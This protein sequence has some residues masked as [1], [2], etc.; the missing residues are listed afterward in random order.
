MSVIIKTW[1]CNICGYVNTDQ[2]CKK[3]GGSKKEQ[4]YTEHNLTPIGLIIGVNLLILFALFITVPLIFS[5]GKQLAGWLASIIL[6]LEDFAYMVFVIRINKSV[7]KYIAAKERWEKHK[8][9]QEELESGIKKVE[10][11]CDCGKCYPDGAIFCAIDGNPLK[12][13]VID[14]YILTC[15]TCK[16]IFQEGTKFCPACGREIMK[17]SKE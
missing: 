10:M 11:V 16:K 12:R 13:R 6:L 8:I 2:V 15:P 14:N 7:K 17:M 3:C 4:R 5:P 1:E 9:Q